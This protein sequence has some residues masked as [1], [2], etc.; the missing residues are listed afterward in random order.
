MRYES[1]VWDWNGTLLD[2]VALALGIVN[3]ILRD[4][5]L[6]SLT[7]ERYQQIFDFPVQLYYERAGIDFS[8]TS[9]EAVS[10]RFCGEFERRF[11]TARLFSDVTSSLAAVQGLGAR[12][13][14]LSSTEHTSLVRM[15]SGLGISGS[16]HDIRGMPDGFARGK[17][18]IGEKLLRAHSID[19]N[20][21]IMVGDTRH[22][23]EV[24]EALGM[25]CVLL[26]TGHHSFER[27]ASVGPPVLESVGHVPDICVSAHEGPCCW[28]YEVCRTRGR[29]TN[30][31]QRL[32]RHR[33]V[34]RK[35][36]AGLV[37]PRHS[38]QR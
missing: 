14:L 3:N 13:F 31:G 17:T 2:D 8:E 5:N 15:V 1:V 19:P 9:F 27:L 38:H 12:Q 35:R 32:G 20:R 4:H 6:D 24:A 25:D 10:D 18:E 30:V 36:E 26:S 11:G 28:R 16:F 7:R 37:R 33:L 21:A 29:P 23:W 22:D 34:E